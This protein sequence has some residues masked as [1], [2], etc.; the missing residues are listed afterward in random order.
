[1]K[2]CFNYGLAYASHFTCALLIQHSE[3]MEFVVTY[4]MSKSQLTSLSTSEDMKL[5]LM[6]ECEISSRIIVTLNSD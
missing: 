6:T 5:G 2:L 3:K 1:M 4:T